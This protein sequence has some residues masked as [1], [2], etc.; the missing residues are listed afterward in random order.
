[1]KAIDM[2]LAKKVFK[3]AWPALIEYF[4]TSLY[5]LV[6]TYFVSK[7]SVEDVAAL[8]GAGYVA[9]AFWIPG[10]TFVT[11]VTIL[12]AQG[13]GA[14]KRDFAKKVFGEA[15]IMTLTIGSLA[16]LVGILFA[17]EIVG[18]VVVD[19]K[20]TAKGTQY[21]FARLL[22]LPGMYIVF[23]I[24]SALR[25]AK[26]TKT[27][28][29]TGI[30]GNVFNMV[31]DPILIFGLFGAPKL[32][33]FGAGIASSLSF[34]MVLTIYLVLGFKGMLTITP[35]VSLPTWN[36]VSKIFKLGVPVAFQRA[37]IRLSLIFLTVVGFSLAAISPY[38]PRFFVSNREVTFLAMIYL[39]LAGTSEPGLSF[40]MT[41]SGVF[42]GSGNTIVP[43]IVNIASMISARL[44][45]GYFL[46]AYVGLGAIGAWIGMFVDVYLRGAVLYTLYKLRYE[47][48]VKILV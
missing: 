28:M 15:L 8:G 26:D 33:I 45:L 35:K 5:T 47:R 43:T 48:L 40:A 6:D 17:R 22:G 25:G 13:L 38:V 14:G 3:L 46:G 20:V 9:W 29:K 19:P 41:V 32:G 1:M 30:L 23:T 31:L 37:G 39:I 7:L 11:G 24:N 16:S 44:A 42:E 12:V 21:L 18:I 27:P 36:I 34:Y 4:L 2:E 10:F